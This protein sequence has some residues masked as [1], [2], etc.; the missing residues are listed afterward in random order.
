M[1][2]YDIIFF[3]ILRVLGVK[4]NSSLD[5]VR[6]LIKC[7]WFLHIKQKKGD[8]YIYIYIYRERERESER[9]IELLKECILERYKGWEVKC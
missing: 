6:I 2:F 9:K 8:I 7:T 3:I 4:F 1:Y 5:R